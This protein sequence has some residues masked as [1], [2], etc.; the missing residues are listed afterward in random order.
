MDGM[1]N[2]VIRIFHVEDYKIMRDGVKLLLQNEPQMKIVGDA[3]SAAALWEALAHTPADVMILDIYLDRMRDLNAS[4]GFEIC[5]LMKEKYPAVGV[6]IHSAYDDGDSISRMLKSGARGFVSKTSGFEEL[7]KAVK[8]VAMGQIY[9]CTDTRERLKNLNAFLLGVENHL[10]E[11]NEIFSHRE[12]EVLTLLA[13]GKSSREIADAL[14]ITERTVETH[15]KNMVEK[16]KVKNTAEL[17]A[18]ASSAG[19]IKK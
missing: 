13:E 3:G 10:K 19:L 12:R 14:L 7:V 11:K 8:A 9:I 1:G 6:I 2:S 4:N 16:V 18:Y 5:A 17:I 15:R